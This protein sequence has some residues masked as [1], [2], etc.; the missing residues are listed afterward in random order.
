M[1]K[2]FDK[3]AEVSAINQVLKAVQEDVDVPKPV[4]KKA[5]EEGLSSRFSFAVHDYGCDD[6]LF[7]S[8]WPTAEEPTVKC[9]SVIRPMVPEAK[10]IDGCGSTEWFFSAAYDTPVKI[11]QL[12]AQRGFILDEELQKTEAS[13]DDVK[14]AVQGT[15]AKKK[16]IKPAK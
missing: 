7:A 5:I 4:L 13:F 8:I 12:L 6:G 2:R 16:T 9:P 3:A 10:G 14:A 1:K 11:A 15:V